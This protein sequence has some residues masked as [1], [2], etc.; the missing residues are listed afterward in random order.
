M[1]ATE[2]ALRATFRAMDASQAHR[3]REAYYKAVEGLQSLATALEIAD[4]DLTGSPNDPILVERV[5]ARDALAT[6]QKSELG[7][8]L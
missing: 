1:S 7:R 5:L 6:M 4:A 8:A 2:R 3:I